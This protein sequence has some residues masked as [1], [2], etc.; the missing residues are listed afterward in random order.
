MTAM[1]TEHRTNNRLEAVFSDVL[2]SL[3]DVIKRHRITWQEYRAATEWLTEAGNQGYEIPLLLD[4]FL[5]TTVDDVNSATNGGTESNAEGPFYIADALMLERP[6]V[7]PRRVNEPGER[8]EFSGDVRFTDGSPVAGAVLDIWQATA[9]G[10]YSHF[11]PG[12]P[13]GNLR[14]RIET[15]AAGQF[16]FET[17]VPAPYEIPKTGATGKLLTA[18]D[19]HCFRPGHIHFK[20]NHHSARPL[21]TQI[22]FE[23]DPW[24]DS[25]VVGAMKDSL[26]TRLLHVSKGTVACSY[27]FILQRRDQVPAGLTGSREMS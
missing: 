21:T 7:L 24:I 11:H 18:L 9:N 6:Y 27:G 3:M 14:G 1:E 15:D 26:V 10:E 25:D 22:Y 5:S 2:S 16:D 23:G 17:V 19:R 8:L 20:L 12:L 4:V 13:D